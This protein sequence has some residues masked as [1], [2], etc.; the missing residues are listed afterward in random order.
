MSGE[1][2]LAG[3]DVGTTNIKAIIFKPDGQTVAEASVPTPTHYPQPTWAYY[4][5][6]E[7]WQATAN[8][9]H[10]VTNRLDNV[11]RVVS[12]AVASMAETSVPLDAQGQP[13]YE[14]IAWFDQRAHPQAEWLK[15][16]V[17]EVHLFNISGLS[18]QPIFGLCKLLW[19]KEHQPDAFAH[20]AL[21]LNTADYI[22]YRLS[23]IPAT[24]YSLASR[25]LALNLARRQWDRELIKEV[26]LSPHLFAPLQSS[27]THLGP[28]TATAAVATGLP[29]SSQVATGG[30][31]H[32]CGALAVGVVQP[33]TMLNSLGTAE[34]TFIPLEQPLTDPALG[35]Q[36]YGQGA[37]VVTNGYYVIGGL[38]T[39]GASVAWWREI[40]DKK[41]DYTALIAEA[42]QVPP[43]SL[44]TCFLPHLRSANPPNGDPR[45]RGAFIGLN[46]DVKRGTLFRAILEGLAYESRHTLDAL[47]AYPKVMAPR[48]IYAIGGSTRN[49]LL[50]QI[51]ATVLNQ[52]ITVAEITEATALGAAILGGLAAGVYPDVSSALATLRYAQTPIDPVADQTSLYDAYFRQIYRQ[53]YLTLRPLHHT[54]YELQNSI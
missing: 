19:F 25:T 17:G 45:G 10:R 13:T 12:V 2:L 39:S 46:T 31:D 35:Q 42:E 36:G 52:T 9:L 51:K 32:I 38:Y 27:G 8:A 14:A 28:V 54:I 5:P 47:L 21:W 30:H 11:S 1:P 3:V 20:T 7:L 50:M 44:G 34:A 22:A 43:G 23:G 18:L 53:I 6:E 48:N 33:G 37:H 29:T 40:L 26:G 49:H 15:Q 41:V 4:D 24:D 16:T